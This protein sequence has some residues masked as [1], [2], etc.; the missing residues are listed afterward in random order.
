MAYRP[1]KIFE[2]KI[3]DTEKAFTHADKK[4]PICG[5][6]FINGD[7]TFHL[8]SKGKKSIGK[9]R[10]Y[11]VAFHKQCVK[12]LIRELLKDILY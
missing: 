2:V 12:Y 6:E 10:T 11:E 7:T 8:F 5:H 4:C 9:H 1:F 3:L